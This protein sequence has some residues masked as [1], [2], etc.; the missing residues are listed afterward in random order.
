[1]K[2]SFCDR[3]LILF[4]IFQDLVRID[5][6]SGDEAAVGDYVKAFCGK[7]GLEVLEDNAG[8]ATG[9]NCGN[10]VIKI[11][12]GNEPFVNPLIL[13][14][15]MDTVSPGRGIK[16]VDAGDRYVSSGDSVLGADDKAGCAEIMTAMHH[17][18]AIN[19]HRAISKV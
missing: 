14:A 9:G 18:I 8:K 11:P 12:Y 4:D 3:A 16:P 13:N 6:E 15:H 5:S 2:K 19:K 1:M 7:L 10:L 17:L